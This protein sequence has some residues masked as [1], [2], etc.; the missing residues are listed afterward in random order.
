MNIVADIVGYTTNTGLTDLTERFVIAED[1][2]VSVGNEVI[3]ATER[4]TALEAQPTIRW[5]KVDA[6]FNGATL[7]RGF[8]ATAVSRIGTGQFLVTFDG[9]IDICGWTA[10]L[11]DN[12]A[13]T[14]LNGQISIEQ[15]ATFD[16]TTLRVRTFSEAGAEEDPPD[17]SG[18]TVTVTC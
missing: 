5:A 10:T 13:G 6:D 7:L 1:Y 17:T 3:L 18:F 2:L 12:A 16:A 14:A 9:P 8:G 11:N 4:L 15:N